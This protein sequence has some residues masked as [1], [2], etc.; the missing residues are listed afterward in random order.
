MCDFK[1]GCTGRAGYQRVGS[2]EQLDLARTGI[3]QIVKHTVLCVTSDS[4]YE[5]EGLLCDSTCK[6]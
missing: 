3:Y 4:V 1:L 6:L 5:N 2:I